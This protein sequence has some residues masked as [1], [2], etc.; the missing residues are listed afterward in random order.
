MNMS[1]HKSLKLLGLVV[2]VPLALALLSLLIVSFV[3]IGGLSLMRLATWQEWQIH[4]YWYFLIARLTLFS[5]AAWGW[6][7]F[8]RRTLRAQ[9]VFLKSLKRVEVTAVLGILLI[10]LVRALALWGE[11]V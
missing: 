3:T 4:N 11:L 5:L 9:P 8:R 10:E 7:W 2:V 6:V 1:T